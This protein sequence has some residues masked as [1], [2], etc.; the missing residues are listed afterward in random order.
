MVSYIRKRNPYDKIILRTQHTYPYLFLA[1]A[2]LKMGI[3]FT[4]PLLQY[5]F[6]KES[7]EATFQRI[8]E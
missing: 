1:G 7:G 2:F 6:Q 8:L 4:A 5:P 3:T